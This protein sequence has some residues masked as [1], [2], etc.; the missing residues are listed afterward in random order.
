MT[1]VA[2][3]MVKDELDMI[4]R[5]IGHMLKHTDYVF[6]ADNMS[7]DGTYERL[8]ELEDQ[9]ISKM[10]VIR[11]PEVAYYQ[12]AKMSR[13][14]ANAVELAG[15]D[16]VVVPFDADEI[17][18]NIQL[19]ETNGSDVW[20]IEGVDHRPTALDDGR[21]MP[22]CDPDRE[23]FMPK[24]AFKWRPGA[25][26]EQGNHGVYYTDGLPV[27]Y[28]G[29]NRILIHHY[30]IR[31]VQQFIRKARNGAVAYNATTLEEDRGAHW[32]RWG[33]MSDQELEAEFYEKFYRETTEGMLD[34]EAS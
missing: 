25:T 29:D 8:L 11:D 14:A 2:V 1:I 13:F 9:H 17:W 22:F 5:S 16:A 7:T 4:D 23:L 10:F 30:P 3:T 34:V 15:G 12:S 20:V 21:F 27:R 33:G 31:S 19:L 18:V 28:G 24:V 6:V 32:R 26:I